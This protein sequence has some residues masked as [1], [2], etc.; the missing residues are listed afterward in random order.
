MEL[1]AAA[2]SQMRLR[3]VPD[4]KP[5]WNTE[6]NYGLATGGTGASSAISDKRQAAYVLRTYL[7]NAANGV[8]RVH[9]Y[10]WDQPSLGNTKMVASTGA[11]TLAGK[12]FGLAQAWMSGGKLVGASRAAKP[13]ARDRAGTYTCVITYA[14][15]VRRVYWN[16]TKR[17]TVTTARTAT[18]KVGVTGTKIAIKKG[19]RQPV[20][21][22]PLM[23]RSK[24]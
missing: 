13:C 5:I 12:A 8:K 23:V 15:G 3:G 24:R 17:V 22:R 14:G 2:R 18:Y 20:D 9:W 16:P 19:S 6:I 1:L 11:P 10:A 21:Y 7:L 4:S